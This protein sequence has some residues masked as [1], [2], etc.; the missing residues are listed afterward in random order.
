MYLK[1]D[2]RL[3]LINGSRGVV[4][5]FTSDG[6]PLVRFEGR[7]TTVEVTR[8]TSTVEEDGR[9]VGSRRMIPLCLAWVH[10]AAPASPQIA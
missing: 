6:Y 10:G 5:G 2:H 1:N 4:T 9:T 8:A 7:D 3:Q